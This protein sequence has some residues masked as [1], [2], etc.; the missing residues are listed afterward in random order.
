M[1]VA[2]LPADNKKPG[3]RRA[4]LLSKIVSRSNYSKSTWRPTRRRRVVAQMVL[5][6]E[7][8]LAHRIGCQRAV[9]LPVQQ[10]GI[11]RTKLA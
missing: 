11:Q 8:I 4:S 5:F 7:Q 9:G 10:S 6:F 3:L 1:P 2:R